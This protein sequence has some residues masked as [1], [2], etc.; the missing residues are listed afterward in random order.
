[1]NIADKN[2]NWN[3][4]MSDEELDDFKRYLS[5][6][7]EDLVNVRPS[8]PKKYFALALCRSLPPDESIKKEF[9]EIS[10]EITFD[11]SPCIDRNPDTYSKDPL[12][13]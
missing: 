10:K 6:A 4:Y 12:T 3:L 7:I 2:E 5:I 13:L 1:M 9:P 11:Y 8:D